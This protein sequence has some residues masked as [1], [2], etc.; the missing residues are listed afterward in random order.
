M[1]KKIQQ[2]AAVHCHDDV[3]RRSLRQDKT[4]ILIRLGP[5]PTCFFKQSFKIPVSGTNFPHDP[6]KP[7][8]RFR[9][10]PDPRRDQ[11]VE[12]GTVHIALALLRI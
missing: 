1:L 7:R 3:A 4:R 12:I 5:G 11:I 8:Q 2:R 9:I 10:F 6:F